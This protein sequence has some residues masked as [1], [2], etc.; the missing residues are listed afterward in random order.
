ML[1]KSYDF[2]KV[3]SN[4]THR[5]LISID[6]TVIYEQN[7]FSKSSSADV[8][9]LVIAKRTNFSDHQS[10]IDKRDYTSDYAELVNE[11]PWLID[12]NSELFNSECKKTTLVQYKNINRLAVKGDKKLC[13]NFL[14]HLRVDQLSDLLLV[15]IFR[16]LSRN[17]DSLRQW[18]NSLARAKEVA[19]KRKLDVREVFLGL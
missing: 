17:K 12:L 16:L 5:P 7:I 14:Y 13:D 1:A 8:I 19:M 15:G 18:N 2:P 11:L 4:N 6:S 9:S 10:T 3:E